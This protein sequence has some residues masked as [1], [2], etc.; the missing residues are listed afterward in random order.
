MHCM[1]SWGRRLIALW[2]LVALTYGG[3]FVIT[4]PLWIVPRE[5]QAAIF[6]EVTGHLC[7]LKA[8]D[9]SH[10]TGGPRDLNP[11]SAIHAGVAG[12]SLHYAARR[13]RLTLRMV[14]VLVRHGY[15]Q[16]WEPAS[17]EAEGASSQ[18]P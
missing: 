2:V 15:A 5:E 10:Y 6:E 8:K 11:S 3:L 14:N 13:H 16:G 7:A 9:A 17:C 1:G 4:N 18:S 12:K